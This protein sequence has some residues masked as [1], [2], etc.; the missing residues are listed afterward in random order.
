MRFRNALFALIAV[1]FL[2]MMVQSSALAEGLFLEPEIGVTK[3]TGDW[4]DILD[5]GFSAGGTLGYHISPMVALTGFASFSAHDPTA[6]QTA[7]EQVVFGFPLT[8]SGGTLAILGG[9]RLYPMAA[10]AG[11]VQLFLGAAIGRSAISL[12]PTSDAKSFGVISESIGAWSIAG[13]GGI[14]VK[15]SSNISIGIGA[16]LMVNSFDSESSE[17]NALDLKGNAFS[18][19]GRLG[20]HF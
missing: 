12:E 10:S 4:G 8:E 20:I 18:G 13:E 11:S 17:G 2:S 16:R 6:E 9:V 3:L 19:F 5:Q 1:T 14:E 15:A 7:A